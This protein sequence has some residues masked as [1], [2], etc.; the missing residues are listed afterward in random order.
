V[1][2]KAYKDF[3]CVSLKIESGNIS[4]NCKY[5]MLEWKSWL[6][7]SLHTTTMYSIQYSHQMVLIQHQ[8]VITNGDHN[9][10]V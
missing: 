6:I 2:L 1:V 7:P 5:S 10:L 3:K 8:R 9:I 4:L